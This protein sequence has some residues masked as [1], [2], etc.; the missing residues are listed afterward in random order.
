MSATAPVSPTGTSG[1]VQVQFQLGLFREEVRVP[2]GNLGYGHAKRLAAEIIGRK[3]TLGGV[4]AKHDFFF[5]LTNGCLYGLRRLHVATATRRADE[6]RYVARV[7][8]VVVKCV[9][10]RPHTRN[11]PLSQ[12][13]GLQME[14]N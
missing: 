14:S 7:K 13:Y 10:F 2:A 12:T 8:E 9:T 5:V 3:V 4:G 6:R 1:P 11:R